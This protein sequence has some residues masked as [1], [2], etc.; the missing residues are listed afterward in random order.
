MSMGARCAWEGKGIEEGRKEEV[1]QGGRRGSKKMQAPSS[2]PA[3]EPDL[4]GFLLP[5]Y[6]RHMRRAIPRVETSNL[7]RKSGLSP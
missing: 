1:K 7:P 5:D 2:S 6:P 3:E 4:S